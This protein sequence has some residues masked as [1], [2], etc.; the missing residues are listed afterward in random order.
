MNYEK[1]INMLLKCVV[2]ETEEDQKA[3]SSE[4]IEEDNMMDDEN[5]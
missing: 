1:I 5:I 4:I 3:Q 2:K